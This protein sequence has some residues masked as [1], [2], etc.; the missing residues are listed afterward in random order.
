MVS[1]FEFVIQR[2]RL[3]QFCLQSDETLPTLK[4]KMIRNTQE[5][6]FQ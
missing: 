4:F 2:N 5:I 1:D 6:I 3:V